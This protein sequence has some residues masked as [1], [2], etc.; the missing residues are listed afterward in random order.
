MSALQPELVEDQQVPKAAESGASFAMCS[1]RVRDCSWWL[2][3]MTGIVNLI[4]A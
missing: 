1:N 4:A 2:K 3:Y